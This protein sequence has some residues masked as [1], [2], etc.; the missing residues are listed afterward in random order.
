M[1]TDFHRKRTGARPGAVTTLSHETRRPFPFLFRTP[2]CSEDPWSLYSCTTPFSLRFGE[3]LTSLSYWTLQRN[4][5]FSVA[6]GKK[7]EVQLDKEN[8]PWQGKNSCRTCSRSNIWWAVCKIAWQ[9]QEMVLSKNNIFSLVL[10]SVV[11]HVVVV[12]HFLVYIYVK[13]KKWMSI[14]NHE[15]SRVGICLKTID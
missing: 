11:Q 12:F 15:I 6:E 1:L 9:V 13:K 5:G 14:N 8:C 7:A 4:M 2:F 10:F 3:M